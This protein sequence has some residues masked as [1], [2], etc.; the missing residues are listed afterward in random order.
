MSNMKSVAEAHIGDTFFSDSKNEI[1][2]FP[3]Y[4]PPQ[5]MV[6][7]GVYPLDPEDYDDLQRSIE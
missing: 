7:A 5:N 2:P 6:F 3:G 4:K 1:K